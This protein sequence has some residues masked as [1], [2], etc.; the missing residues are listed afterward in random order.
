MPA[1][2]NR[3][4]STGGRRPKA[5]KERTRGGD[6]RRAPR[7]PLWGF[8]CGG[9]CEREC[10]DLFKVVDRALV[11]RQP[12][13]LMVEIIV[14]SSNCGRTSLMGRRTCASMVA[15][16][17]QPAPSEVV[18]ASSQDSDR[19]HDVSILMALIGPVGR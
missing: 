14:E 7:T 1:S 4:T 13:G 6:A 11:G 9:R 18:I 2:E 12:L 15:A 17:P 10:A 5:A 3:A 19:G 16:G 8:G